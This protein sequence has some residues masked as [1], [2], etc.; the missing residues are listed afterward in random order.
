VP[1]IGRELSIP[2]AITQKG[3]VGFDLAGFVANPFRKLNGKRPGQVQCSGRRYEPGLALM[4][5]EM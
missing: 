1:A 2:A 4:R 3:L 5:V